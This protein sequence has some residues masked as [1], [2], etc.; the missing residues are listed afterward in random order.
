MKDIDT[1]L[2]EYESELKR[3]GK[4]EKTINTYIAAIKQFAIWLEETNGEPIDFEKEGIVLIDAISYKSYMDTVKKYKFNAINTKLAAIQNF[5]DY[6]SVTYKREAIKIPK[7]KG[8]TTPKVEILSKQELYQFLR[9]VD[10][11]ANLLHK[12]LIY[13][14]LYTGMRESEAADLELDDIINLDSSKGS[15]IIIRSGKGDKYREVNISG[16]CKAILREYLKHRPNSDS[17]K[18]F[19][20]IRGPLTASGIYKAVSRLGAEKGLHVYPHMF[21]HQFLTNLSKN[22]NTLNDMKS[23]QE[24]AGH[25]T[26]ETT[27][28][29]YV[30]STE[31]SKQKLIQDIDFFS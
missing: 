23:L 2:S 27:M 22:C 16:R 18:V 17:N 9:Y 14:L 25:S 7:K 26:L 24:I 6:L 11:N 12:T 29:Y 28:K 5:C 31:E 19:V 10:G 15:Y 4:S 13:T 21:R 3:I 30:S 8:Y 1:I 20:G